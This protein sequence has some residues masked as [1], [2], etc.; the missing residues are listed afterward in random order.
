MVILRRNQHN[1]V[2]QNSSI[3]QAVQ[4]SNWNKKDRTLRGRRN[5]IFDILILFFVFVFILEFFSKAIDDD[6]KQGYRKCLQFVGPVG[7]A[8][9]GNFH[10]K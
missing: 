4:Y 2:F 9:T 5:N 7:C 8:H 6:P 10:S 1:V 3:R